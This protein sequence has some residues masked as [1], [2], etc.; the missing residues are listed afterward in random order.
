MFHK[1]CASPNKFTHE[2]NSLAPTYLFVNEV[3]HSF[4]HPFLCWILVIIHSIGHAR[5][6]KQNA[7]TQTTEHSKLEH[8]KQNAKYWTMTSIDQWFEPKELTERCEW[9]IGLKKEHHLHLQEICSKAQCDDVKRW[10]TKRIILWRAQN[11]KSIKSVSEWAGLCLPQTILIT[12][13]STKLH[14]QIAHA[15]HTEECPYNI[16]WKKVPEPHPQCLK[17]A[18][19]KPRLYSKKQHSST[20]VEGGCI[21]IQKSSM[22]VKEE[23]HHQT[24]RKRK[25]P[26]NQIFS[27]FWELKLL[28][29]RSN[30]LCCSICQLKDE[31]WE[32]SHLLREKSNHI[33]AFQEKHSLPQFRWVTNWHQFCKAQ[34][35]QIR[36]SSCSNLGISGPSMDL[37]NEDFLL[38][39]GSLPIA[40]ARWEGGWVWLKRQKMMKEAQNATTPIDE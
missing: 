30:C 26:K 37:E 5:D 20:S 33:Y 18:P 29:G 6:S 8:L 19:I 12:A 9:Y 14:D 13:W 35:K 11:L 40:C 16:K 36:Y 27:S 22:F 38:A 34:Q 39:D 2:K 17:A 28:A 1:H 3:I 10:V 32:N 15:I 24:P 7:N 4:L 31:K 21:Q 25:L 23:H